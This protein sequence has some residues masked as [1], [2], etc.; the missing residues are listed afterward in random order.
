MPIYQSKCCSHLLGY[1]CIHLPAG[2]ESR[3]VATLEEFS[4]GNLV[5]I[6][7]LHMIL[8]GHTGV[9]KTSVV[10]HL[11]GEKID[12]DENST[13]VMEPQLLVCKQ[14]ELLIRETLAAS[15]QGTGFFV[16][17]NENYR[18]E[19]GKFYL[20]IWD[21]GG[22]SMF[23]DLLPCFAKLRSLYGVVFKLTDDLDSY[24]KNSFRF[25]RQKYS[26]GPCPY[27]NKD[28]IYRCLGYIETFSSSIK[29]TIPRLPS[30][31]VDILQLERE[32]Q[33]FPIAVLIGTYR[34]KFEKPDKIEKSEK[35]LD[36]LV[37]FTE[38]LEKV[39]CL[40]SKIHYPTEAIFQI[41][42]YMLDNTKAGSRDEIDEG[43][44]VL[45]EDISMLAKKTTVK[46][47]KNWL[48]F[49]QKLEEICKSNYPNGIIPFTDVSKVAEECHI[50]NVIA[51]LIY[52][53]ELG[54]FLWYY[55]SNRPTLKDYVVLD[56]EKLLKVLARIFDA[57][58]YGSFSCEWKRL[59]SKGILE[60]KL[61]DH[62]L[63]EQKT[64][65]S[66]Q[67][68]LE[69]LSEH[70]VASPID[71]KVLGKGHFIPSMLRV[72]DKLDC[73]DEPTSSLYIVLNAGFVPPGLFPKWVTILSNHN[74]NLGT[75]HWVLCEEELYRNQVKFEVQQN[76]RVLLTE[77]VDC[78]QVECCPPPS[79][80]PDPQVYRTVRNVL[81]VCLFRTVPKW[82]YE[83]EYQ[84][85]F[86]CTDASHH[87]LP[88]DAIT[89][90][91]VTCSQ[92][93]MMELTEGQ[94]LWLGI[95][96]TMPSELLV[97]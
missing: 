6:T 90:Q 39:E 38:N 17:E 15:L 78:I 21:T 65:I 68:V 46:V 2:E 31:I 11:K 33:E 64:G 24:P 25:G 87:L 34:D 52:F 47:P 13:E 1:T 30:E 91:N 8:I 63:D 41:P 67:W 97:E 84:F 26:T 35:L 71:H 42:V 58:G 60:K 88:A 93:Q 18:A 48:D 7:H 37:T 3:C 82:I 20:N 23:Q 66:T 76:Y 40:H 74:L 69:F 59:K 32:E 57:K 53:H 5:E 83:R 28:L 9:G 54:F 29:D 81:D 62:C 96:R 89:N 86:A 55:Y 45:V 70:Y 75:G 72:R 14:P 77:H 27:S 16:K 12:P 43:V 49:K 80:T 95:G 50:S 92:H 4:P 36:K 56:P 22:Q 85:T 51:P 10:K 79:E 94:L 44:Q 61:S 73:L 19:P